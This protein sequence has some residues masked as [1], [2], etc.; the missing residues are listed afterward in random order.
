[1]SV[2]ATSAPLPDASRSAWLAM[3]LLMATT[4]LNVAD[5]NLISILVR[6]HAENGQEDGKRP[7][8]LP[9]FVIGFLAFATLNSL[10]FIPEVISSAMASLSR[11]ALLISIAAVGMKTSLKR[12]LDVGGQAIILIVAETVFIALFVLSGVALA[13]F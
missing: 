6:R 11:W 8:I 1:M 2:P 3:A 10:G 5:R 12:I 9:L 13:H 7:P 4:A